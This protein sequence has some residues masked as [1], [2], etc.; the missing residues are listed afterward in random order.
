MTL[1]ITFFTDPK[2]MI[3]NSTLNG[4]DD[5]GDIQL[6]TWESDS[7]FIYLLMNKYWSIGRI[8]FTSMLRIRLSILYGEIRWRNYCNITG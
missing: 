7:L 6:K 1:G 3:T 2:T 4:T 5:Y 8:C